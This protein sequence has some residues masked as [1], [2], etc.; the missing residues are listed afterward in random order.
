MALA[1]ILGF[2]AVEVAV[3]AIAHSL[4]LLSDAA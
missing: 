4:A 1:L 3:G 2:M